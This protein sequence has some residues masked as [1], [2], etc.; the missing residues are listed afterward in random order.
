MSDKLK[1]DE[2]VKFFGHGSALLPPQAGL[3]I[4]REDKP[5]AGR[6][7]CPGLPMALPLRKDFPPAGGRCRVSDKKGNLARQRLRGFIG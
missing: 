1:R 7:V 6:T 4:L 3:S 5:S 2:K